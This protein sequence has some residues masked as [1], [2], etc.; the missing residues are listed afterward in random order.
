M[1]QGEERKYKKGQIILKE[2]SFELAIYDV[3]L[4]RVGVYMNYGTPEEKLLTT[5]ETERFFGEMG[6][7]EGR[8]RSATAVALEKDTRLKV[9][10]PESFDAYF[11]ESPAKVLLIMQNMSHRIRELTRD[12]LEA[13][14]AVAEAVETEKTGKEKSSWFKEKVRKLMDDYERA[15]IAGVEEGSS[16]Y[17][18]I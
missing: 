4:G 8:L 1:I 10:T 18:R 7:I 6:M 11:K 15:Y 5:L 17:V 12:Y 16:P 9:I 3:M 14:R 2:K 13:C